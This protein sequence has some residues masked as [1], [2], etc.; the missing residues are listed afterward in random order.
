MAADIGSY[1]G[2]TNNQKLPALSDSINFFKWKV[3]SENIL[4]QKGPGVYDAV[5]LDDPAPDVTSDDYNAWRRSNLIA[6]GLLLASM[7]I[8]VR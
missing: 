4:M 1:Y 3:D 2:T 7:S 5:M 6:K 8:G